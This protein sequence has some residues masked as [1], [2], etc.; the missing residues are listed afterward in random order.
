MGL[1][2]HLSNSSVI[3]AMYIHMHYKYRAKK[4][5][6]NIHNIITGI[7]LHHNYILDSWA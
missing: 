2:G 7:L 3:F 1:I 6:S 5:F 4:S